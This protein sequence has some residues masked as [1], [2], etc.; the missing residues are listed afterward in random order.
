VQIE[1][2]P[3]MLAFKTLEYL[4]AMYTNS[5]GY[6]NW[7]QAVGTPIPDRLQGYLA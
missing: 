2:L 7:S 5:T 4:R 1:K 3:K 6:Q